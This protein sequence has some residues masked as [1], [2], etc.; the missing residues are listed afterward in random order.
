[1]NSIS[2]IASATPA[3]PDEH[4]A[5]IAAIWAETQAFLDADFAAWS[6][7]W[8]QDERTQDVYVSATAGLSVLSGW[9]A[10]AAH[11]KAVLQSGLGCHKTQI[12]QTNHQITVE[13]D[14]AWVVFDGWSEAH[15]GAT[16]LNFE[17]RILE[18]QSGA[19]KIVYSS[20]MERSEHN[21]RKNEISV[22]KEGRLIFATHETLEKLKTHPVLTISAG[23]VRAHRRDW[24]KQLQKEIVRAGKYH[25]FFELHRFSA[26]TGGTFQYPVVLG[27]SHDG[28]VAV[29]MISVRDCVTYLRIDGD[30]II[31]RRLAVAQVVFGLSDGQMRVANRIAAGDGL[32]KIAEALG[33]SV[34]T[35]R[36][37]LGRIFEKTGVNSQTALVR[38]LLSVG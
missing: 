10:V 12:R 23:R 8:V 20:V 17:T 38:L 13:Q 28:G 22:D 9:A 29:T 11:M 21:S 36:T 2:D 25:G 6:T 26:E 5:I 37:H 32:Q 31:E 24:D 18:R 33:I 14:T 30:E 4:K 34:N 16:D 3:I 27:G 19:W 35:A 1:M 7:C 15:S